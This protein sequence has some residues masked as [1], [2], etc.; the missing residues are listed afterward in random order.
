MIVGTVTLPGKSYGVF[1]TVMTTQLI[2]P[3]DITNNKAERDLEV[4]ANALTFWIGNG[5]C[6]ATRILSI[7]NALQCTALSIR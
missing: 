7:N 5:T 4:K 6:Y 2:V 3:L 1:T